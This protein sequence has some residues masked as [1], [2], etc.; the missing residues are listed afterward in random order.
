MNI[1][2]QKSLI[3]YAKKLGVT[4]LVSNDGYL[5]VEFAPPAAAAPTV[6]PVVQLKPSE[7]QAARDAKARL[8]KEAAE[9]RRQRAFA[10]SGCV[11]RVKA[12]D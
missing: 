1:R 10:A 5:E 6:A 9:R 4:R 2:G 12:E 8:G 3:A 11:P 7:A